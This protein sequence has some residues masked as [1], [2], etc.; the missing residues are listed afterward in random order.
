MLFSSV[1]VRRKSLQEHPFGLWGLPEAMGIMLKRYQ[2]VF[3]MS[4]TLLSPSWLIRTEAQPDA[5]SASAATAAS[6]FTAPPPKAGSRDMSA[7]TAREEA[8]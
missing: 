2:P 1:T 3:T 7:D 5:A 8:G 6:R 4:T